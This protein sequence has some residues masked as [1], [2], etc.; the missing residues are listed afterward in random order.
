MNFCADTAF[1][2]LAITGCEKGSTVWLQAVSDR[3][4]IAVH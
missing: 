2:Q 1:V 4:Y 3:N